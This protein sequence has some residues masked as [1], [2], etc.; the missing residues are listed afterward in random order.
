LIKG[1]S[2]YLGFGVTIGFVAL[3]V[4]RTD[5]HELLSALTEANYVWVIPA[6]ATT[7]ASY[8]LRTVRWERILRPVRALSFRTL[9]PVV[10]I[11]FMANNLLPARMGE[12]VRAYALGRKTGLS[13]SMSLATIL[14][15]RLCDGITLVAALGVVAVIYPLPSWG[16]QVGIVAGGVFLLGSVGAVFALSHEK[17]TLTVLE[18]LLDRLP[19][20]LGE[21]IHSRIGSFIFGLGVLRSGRAVVALASWS[22]LVWTVE[23]ST[24]YFVLKSVHPVLQSGTLAIAA[25]LLMVTINLGILIPSAPGYVGAY[26]AFGILALGAFGVPTSVALA[27]TIVAHAEQWTTVTG[28]G[29]FFLA[30]ESLALGRLT[31]DS[32]APT[33]AASATG[34]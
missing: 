23:T 4:W 13:K 3:L 30:R 10:F 15:E 2:R 8:A 32:A 16:R 29:L 22:L 20:D 9:L 17:T 21:R 33:S 25:L 14:L 12:V 34:A 5:V 11:G 24:Y 31:V 28:I 7:L 1:R 18:R 6:V 27:I 26:Q 19:G